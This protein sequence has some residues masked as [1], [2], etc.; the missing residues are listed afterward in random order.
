[1]KKFLFILLT[2]TV[3]FVNAQNLQGGFFAGLSTSQVDGDAQSGYNMTGLNLGFLTQAK[4]GENSD[5]RLELAFL[6]KGA[7]EDINDSTG[8]GN[9]Y[10]LKL[11]YIEVPVIYI[12]NWKNFSFEGGIGADILVSKNE[13]NLGGTFDSDVNYKRVSMMLLFGVSYNFNDNFGVTLRTNHSVTPISDIVAAGQ[14]PSI[15]ALGGYGMRNDV[16][17][18]ALVYKFNR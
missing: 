15:V 13:S 17:T 8:C 16:L 7:K 9:C 10:R 14:Q 2:S 4:I 5:L 3:A 1:M 11:N 18:L 6:Q 12:L